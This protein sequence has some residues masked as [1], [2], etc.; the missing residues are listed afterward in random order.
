ML[1]DD[2]KSADLVSTLGKKWLGVTDTVMGGV[3]RVTLA[4]AELDGRPCLR[5]SGDVS[6][7]NGGG[8]VQAALQ[9]AESPSTLD[10]SHCTGIR[11]LVRGNGEEYGVHLRTTDVMRSWQSYRS[12]FTP[13]TEWREV[14]LPFKLFRPHR[15]SAPLDLTKLRRLGLVAIGRVFHADLAVAEISLYD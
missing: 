12:Q 9:L 14:L 1:I 11:L 4:P 7:E 10:V 2:F 6:L 3:S 8:F 15:L 5:M 13:G